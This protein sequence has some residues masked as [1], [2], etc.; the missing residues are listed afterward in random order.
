VLGLLAW[1]EGNYD[2]AIANFRKAGELARAA[3]DRKLEGSS[4]NNLSLVYDEQGDYDTS[5]EQYR[6]VLA[7][8]RDVDFRAASATRSATSAASTCCSASFARL[9]LTTSRRSGSASSW[10]PGPR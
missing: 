9:S 6:Q 2:A 3:G 10:N 5:L 4:L 8:Y 7:L 1:D